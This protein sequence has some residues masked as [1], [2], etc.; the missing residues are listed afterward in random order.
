MIPATFIECM[1][2]PLAVIGTR[3]LFLK[4]ISDYDAHR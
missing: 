4:G 2:D 1:E 3:L